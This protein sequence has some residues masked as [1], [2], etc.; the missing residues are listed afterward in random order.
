MTI[1]ECPTCGGSTF[2][3]SAP[4]A[5]FC[6]CREPKIKE[7]HC[8]TCGKDIEP[9]RFSSLTGKIS[10]PKLSKRVDQSMTQSHSQETTQ[11]PAESVNEIQSSNNGINNSEIREMIRAQNRT[12][13]AVRAFVR[14]LFIQLS[15]TTAAIAIW[16][17][18]NA[19]INQED[20]VAYGNNCTGNGFLQFV[21]AVILIGGII[22]SSVAGWDELGKSKVD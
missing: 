12:T 1:F 18:S 11:G 9:M 4:N 15:A 5:A 8:S 6:Q 7:Q 2:V 14:F 13:H 10:D 17:L 19:F 21:A 16:N 22:W 3:H 20:C